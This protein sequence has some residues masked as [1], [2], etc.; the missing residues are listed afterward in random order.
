[1]TQMSKHH[2]P[3]FYTDNT[4]IQEDYNELLSLTTT[5]TSSVIYMPHHST[6]FNVVDMRLKFIA[7]KCI[8][9]ILSTF[10]IQYVQFCN[11]CFPIIQQTRFREPPDLGIKNGREA[12]IS[13][14]HSHTVQQG[15]SCK[16]GNIR[17]TGT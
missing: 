14:N 11:D 2:H 12:Q 16:I 4:I 3:H 7:V 8:I 17:F 9:F 13:F 1:M 10:V 5:S 6:V 15:H